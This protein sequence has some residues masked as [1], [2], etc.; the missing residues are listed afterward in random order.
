MPRS[1][2]ARLK[3]KTQAVVDGQDQ[4]SGVPRYQAPLAVIGVV[5]LLLFGFSVTPAP[6]KPAV[7]PRASTVSGPL[8][9]NKRT[10]LAPLTYAPEILRSV[11]GVRLTPAAA[12]SFSR[13]IA[14]AARDHVT[15]TAVS[16]YRSY[17]EQGLLYAQYSQS[18]GRSEADEI[19]ARA[20]FSEHQTGLAVDVGNPGGTCALQACF[21]R[22]P[23]GAWVQRNAW[24]YGFIVRYPV[25]ATA[26]TGYEY[27]PWHLRYVGTTVAEDMRRQGAATLEEF[28]NAPSAPSY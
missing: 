9:V 14:A 6:S 23:A 7:T 1:Q 28:S 18:Y 11:A 8:L 4:A 5:C 21:A 27:E 10:P 26:V 25:N 19:S 17:R 15:I 20:G 12:D 22:T 2:H 3:D 13:M 24:R 16:G